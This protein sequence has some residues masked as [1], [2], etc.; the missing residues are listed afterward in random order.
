[1]RIEE[2]AHRGLKASTPHELL[3]VVEEI[4]DLLSFL[5]ANNMGRAV[6]YRL[7]IQ[8]SQRLEVH[9]GKLE[10][11]LQFNSKDGRFASDWRIFLREDFYKAK[12]E[13]AFLCVISK[14]IML[15]EEDVDR[16]LEYNQNRLFQL[17]AKIDPTSDERFPDLL[18]DFLS[19]LKELEVLIGIFYPQMYRDEDYEQLSRS[20]WDIHILLE[21]W[22]K[23]ST[24]STG[25][26]SSDWEAYSREDLRLMI[27][28]CKKSYYCGVRLLNKLKYLKM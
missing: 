23:A 10:E 6:I 20:I 27:E 2:I 26:F 22:K 16:E 14:V 8:H 4:R 9:G 28:S 21:R 5:S 11:S 24:Y 25:K 17:K 1:M 12:E 3:R 7:L 18:I 15:K 13:L 19:L